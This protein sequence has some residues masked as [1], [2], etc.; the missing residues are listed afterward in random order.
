MVGIIAAAHGLKEGQSKTWPDLTMA[1]NCEELS[2]VC[3]Q[4]V[5]RVCTDKHKKSN[6]PSWSAATAINTF[7][8][9]EG[10][11]TKNSGIFYA[12]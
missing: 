9:H 11:T 1:Y 10:T 4:A 2:H 7:T 6:C 8:Q 12:K 5:T 3:S